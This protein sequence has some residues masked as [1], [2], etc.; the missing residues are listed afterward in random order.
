MGDLSIVCAGREGRR[1]RRELCTAWL[2]V[3]I[4]TFK[5]PGDTRLADLHQGSYGDEA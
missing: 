1:G 2:G 5:K 3:L 4:S